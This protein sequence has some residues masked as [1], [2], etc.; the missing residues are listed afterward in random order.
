MARGALGN[1]RFRSVLVGL[2][3]AAVLAL[4]VQPVGAISA[5]IRLSKSSGPP[6]TLTTVRGQGF[7][8]S[9][10]VDIAF[11]DDPVARAVTGSSGS[12]TKAITVPAEALPG[13]HTVSATG[14][15]SGLSD[16]ATFTVRTDWTKFHFD[17]ANTGHNP[18]ENVLGPTNVGTL[19][20][21]WVFPAGGHVTTSPAVVK[22]VVYVG[23]SSVQVGTVGFYAIDAA[24]GEVLWRRRIPGA[25][26][27]TGGPSVWKGIVYFS[28][29]DHTLRAYRAPTGK[30]LWEFNPADGT[31]VVSDGTLY[32]FD[33]SGAVYALDPR[34]GEEIWRA[35]TG[36]PIY[37]VSA[38]VAGGLVYIGSANDHKVHA[39]DAATGEEVWSTAT[40]GQISSS[41]AVADGVL[42]IGSQD[43]NLYAMD[44]LTG[45]IVWTATTGS[46]VDSSPVV[47]Y[48]VVYVGSAD[49]N[50]YA[51]D[52]DTGDPIWV[53][54]TGD[55]IAQA[56]AAVANRV[57]YIGSGDEN[58]YAFDAGTGE[59]LWTWATGG[60]VNTP[61]VADGVVYVGTLF[62]GFVYAF[63]L[64]T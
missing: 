61:A 49:G 60:I 25:L 1:R 54:S 62:D 21:K 32:A 22:G 37:A 50:V 33:N 13:H 44:A 7:G 46:N 40:G 29:L 8:P 41:P 10:V 63:G 6:T 9:E 51:F 57:L 17:L 19:E 5:S 20:P 39:F 58:I 12:F 23:I 53:A 18:Y 35:F 16:S 64:P 43:H 26:D 31:A 15:S 55:V 52:A 14:R 56:S 47:A 45:D 34:T 36:A 48:G 3:I 2:A 59:T 4:P 30:L 28:A 27:A 42:Y 11:D 38:A 24:T